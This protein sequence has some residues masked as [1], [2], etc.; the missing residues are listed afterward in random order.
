MDRCEITLV[1]T[2][3]SEKIFV[4]LEGN[5]CKI[6]LQISPKETEVEAVVK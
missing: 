5:F 1:V 3:P 6:L 4:L 2:E